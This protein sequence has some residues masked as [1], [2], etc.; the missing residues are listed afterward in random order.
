VLTSKSLA[1][2]AELLFWRFSWVV[3]VL[4]DGAA[5]ASENIAAT[6][7]SENFMMFD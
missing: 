4:G 7:M 5:C 2:Q 1:T 3:Q 6:V